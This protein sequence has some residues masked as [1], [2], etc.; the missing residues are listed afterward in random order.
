MLKKNNVKLEYGTSEV[1]QT[2][3]DQYVIFT[4]ITCLYKLIILGAGG[5]GW[6]E[7]GLGLSAEAAAPATR[8]GLSGR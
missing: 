3:T 2:E 4:W 7:G 6:G 1:E 5:G 8:H